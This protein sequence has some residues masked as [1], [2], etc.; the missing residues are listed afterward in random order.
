MVRNYP[1][2]VLASSI[3]VLLNFDGFFLA[4]RVNLKVSNATDRFFLSMFA[5]I[6]ITV[7]FN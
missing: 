5:E 4:E 1:H 7:I 2:R 6:S 3:I